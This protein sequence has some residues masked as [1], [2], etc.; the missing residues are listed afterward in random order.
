MKS[1]KLK[2]IQTSLESARIWEEKGTDTWQ[3][4][5]GAQRCVSS[6]LMNLLSIAVE[7]FSTQTEAADW[8]VENGTLGLLRRYHK[9]LERLLVEGDAGRIPPSVYGGNYSHL[10]F[11]H[12]SGSPPIMWILV[13]VGCRRHPRFGIG[14]A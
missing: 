12:L 5:A 3:N 9:H 14:S 7:E 1:N 6:A 4:I 10:V 11:A 13:V 8:L 2:V